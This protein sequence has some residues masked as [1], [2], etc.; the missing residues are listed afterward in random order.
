[1]IQTPSR[2][3]E[4]GNA[5]ATPTAVPSFVKKELGARRPAADLRRT[6]APGTTAT[7]LSSG[8]A[9]TSSTGTV[10]VTQT[11]ATS[12]NWVRFANGT[13]RSTSYGN[14][15]IVLG[16]KRADGEQYM[17]VYK[18]IKAEAEAAATLAYDL[19]YG[20]AVPATMTN[21][22]TVNNGQVDVQSV[23]LTPVVVTKVNIESTVVQDGFWSADD[24]CT[25]QVASACAA[26]GIA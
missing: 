3:I 18:A 6:T 7:I 19:A 2:S 8:Y 9:V 4:I 13:T 12:T 14:E 15:A 22:K 1:M 24:I 21:G 10:R 25:S 16:G 11:G 5:E 23:L 20:V 26:A 17:T